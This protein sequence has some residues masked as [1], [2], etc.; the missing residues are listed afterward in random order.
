ML[1]KKLRPSIWLPSIMVAWGIVVSEDAKIT[2]LRVMLTELQMTL[3]GLV[4]DFKGLLIARI[5][6]GVTEAG[7]FPG[8]V[9]CTHS[10]LTLLKLDM[11][12]DG[13]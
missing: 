11:L 4:K 6:L 7:L 13:R 8:V 2:P 3:M 12:T 9:F 1:L 10:Y 5:F